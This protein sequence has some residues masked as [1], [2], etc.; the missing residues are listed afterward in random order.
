MLYEVIT[1]T[2]A[3]MAQG[4]RFY[5]S[6]E[7]EIDAEARQKFLTADKK[8]ILATV[9]SALSQLATIDEESIAEAFT[10]IME[11]TGL[12]LGKFGPSVRVALT[13]TTSSP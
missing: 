6:S 11:K 8:E 12:K 4:A 7:P 9:I 1:R 10:A 2:L 13:G 5:F 3:E